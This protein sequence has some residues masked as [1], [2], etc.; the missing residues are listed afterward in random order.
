VLVVLA[1]SFFNTRRLPSERLNGFGLARKPLLIA[2]S[3]FVASIAIVSFD[4]RL[5]SI[6]VLFTQAALITFGGAYSVMPFVFDQAV[7]EMGWLTSQQMLDG[8][9]LGEA[10]PGPLIMVNAFV[11][12][13][14]GSGFWGALV[15]TWFT[16][17]PSFFLVFIFAPVFESIAHNQR[18]RAILTL[19]SS[20]VVGLI[21]TLALDVMRQLPAADVVTTVLVAALTLTLLIV[22]RIP[23]LAALC[24]SVVSYTLLTAI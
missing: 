21:A 14:A 24:V 5:V 15:A 11:G 16:F 19:L 2:L 9:V 8:L 20:M 6:A 17:V 23:I 12:Y 22:R 10:T 1:L 7:N 13:I 18:V 3:V 4:E